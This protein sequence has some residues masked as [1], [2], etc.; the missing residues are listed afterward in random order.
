M[1]QIDDGY[2]AFCIDEAAAYVAARLQA[3][4]KPLKRDNNRET[5]EFL[6]KGRW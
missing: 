5:A 2:T 6:K 4:D 3:G 1:L